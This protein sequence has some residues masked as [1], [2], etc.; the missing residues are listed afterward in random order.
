MKKIATQGV[1]VNTALR[2]AKEKA[3]QEI[4]AQMKQ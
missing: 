1:D 2:E 3:D 4:A